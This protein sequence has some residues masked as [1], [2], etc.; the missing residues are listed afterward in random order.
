MRRG[1]GDGQLPPKGTLACSLARWNELGEARA[2]CRTRSRQGFSL[3]PP[4][5]P[6]GFS[7]PPAVP[8]AVTQQLLPACQWCLAAPG[9]HSSL[10]SVLCVVEAINLLRKGEGGRE[11][12]REG[13]GGGEVRPTGNETDW[14]EGEVC[15]SLW[16]GD[17][18]IKF[19]S[20][21]SAAT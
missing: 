4:P 13:K 6:V 10:C 18:H 5:S 19:C 1:Q 8:T 2:C 16:K 9:A 7:A 11:G 12:E 14:E 21:P 3:P 17:P 15:L 20:L